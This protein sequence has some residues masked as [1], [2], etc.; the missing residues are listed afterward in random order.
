[1]LKLTKHVEGK[2]FNIVEVEV[3]IDSPISE[4]DFEMHFKLYPMVVAWRIADGK[5]IYQPHHISY[6]WK[7]GLWHIY[8]FL[9][10]FWDET[11]NFQTFLEELG[12]IIEHELLHRCCLSESE[13]HTFYNYRKYNSCRPEVCVRKA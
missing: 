6:D 10:L 7:K 4:D 5:E 12:I 13:V 1:V 3:G 9:S 2:W 8:I 11:E